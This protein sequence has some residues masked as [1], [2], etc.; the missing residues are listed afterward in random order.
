M[1]LQNATN[2]ALQTAG[3]TSVSLCLFTEQDLQH[4][5]VSL[6]LELHPLHNKTGDVWHIALP[7]LD[8]S[9]LYGEC[10]LLHAPCVSLL[11]SQGNH[12]GFRVSGSHQEEKV[13]DHCTIETFETL[14]TIEE[15]VTV[16]NA[17]QRFTNVGD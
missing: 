7:G 16:V 2:F 6:E 8:G 12:A 5:K 15:V 17:G 10:L 1:P 14:Q 11:H 13:I 9:L 4:G 3:A